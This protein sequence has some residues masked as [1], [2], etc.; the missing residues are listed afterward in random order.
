MRKR[1]VVVEERQKRAKRMKRKGKRINSSIQFL[2]IDETSDR[3]ITL[4]SV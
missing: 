3:I 1:D 2:M 4:H